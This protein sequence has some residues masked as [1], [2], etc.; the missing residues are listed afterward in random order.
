MAKGHDKAVDYW[1]LGV[2]IYE[3]LVG[4]SPFFQPHSSQMDMFKRSAYTFEFFCCLLLKPKL[5]LFRLSLFPAVVLVKFETP[6]FVSDSA[7]LIIENLL[8][9]RQASRLGNLAKGYLDIKNHVWFEELDF[10]ALLKKQA[11]APWKPDVKNPLDSSNF[12]DFSSVERE[13]DTGRRL[14]AEEQK[15]FKGF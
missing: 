14:T 3:L 7:K 8:V 2:L 12:D 4:Q 6:N 11:A 1:A 10:T 5:T 9:R 13:R 15:K